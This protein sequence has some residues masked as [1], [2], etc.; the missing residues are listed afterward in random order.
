MYGLSPDL[1][2]SFLE[3]IDLLQVCI[4]ANEVILHFDA[5]VSITIQSALRIRSTS[6]RDKIF[7]EPPS[8]AAELME[9]LSDSP[10]EVAGSEDGTLRLIF[11]GGGLLEIYD[12]SRQY[13]SYLIRHGDELYVV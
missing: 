1:D 2:L 8:A 12:S 10:A 3:G 13:E 7:E 11:S 4:G 5:N 6:G 9:F